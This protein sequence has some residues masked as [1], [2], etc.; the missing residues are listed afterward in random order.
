MLRCP[1]WAQVSLGSAGR[2]QQVPAESPSAGV[3]ATPV[4]SV[5]DPRVR[6]LARRLG[7]KRSEP[8]FLEPG[9]RV[10][11]GLGQV[12]ACD[13]SGGAGTHP[14]RSYLRGF[15]QQLL[16]RMLPHVGSWG[17]ERGCLAISMWLSHTCRGQPWG[18]PGDSAG[19]PPQEMPFSGCHKH[20]HHFDSTRPP[21][22]GTTP[23]PRR[24]AGRPAHSYPGD[25]W[26]S[27]PPE[28]LLQKKGQRKTRPR[29]RRSPEGPLSAD[30]HFRKCQ[31]KASRLEAHCTNRGLEERRPH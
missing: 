28:S 27:A 2:S 29:Q 7:R 14:G 11:C 31:M 30:L 19:R 22:P 16:P 12:L 5:S 8:Q 6:A 9:S 18:S 26:A 17:C 23:G 13:P 24:R 1:P 10:F 3:Q 21:V 15:G 20:P 4:G 25:G